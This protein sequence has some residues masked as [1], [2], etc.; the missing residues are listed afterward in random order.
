MA[1]IAQLTAAFKYYR[2][3]EVA[4]GE[5]NKSLMDLFHRRKNGGEDLADKQHDNQSGRHSSNDHKDTGDDYHLLL[6]S[7]GFCFSGNEHIIYFRSQ[8]GHFVELWSTLILYHSGC[9]F[10]MAGID[11]INDSGG[12]RH[13]G[14]GSCLIAGQKFHIQREYLLKFF[15]HGFHVV[16]TLKGN[17]FQCG[18][19]GIIGDQGNIADISGGNIGFQANS[20]DQL[21]GADVA[22]DHIIISI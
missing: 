9:L 21:I 5:S 6:V 18:V 22:V 16:D 15:E 4:L 13:P 7:Y 19:I 12:G 11:L 20:G 1:H 8:G 10:H 14:T 17:G 3:I 2:D